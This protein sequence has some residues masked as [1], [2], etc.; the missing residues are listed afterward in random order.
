MSIY[1]NVSVTK[2]PNAR[3]EIKGAILSEEF[4][5]FRLKAIKNIGANLEWP[6]FR[7][8][9]VPEK[10]LVER[11]GENVIL[12]EIAELALREA[13]PDILEEH[14]IEAIGRPRI[15]I[16]K[17]APGNPIEFSAITSIMPKFDLPDY[18]SIAGQIFGAEALPPEITVVEIDEAI[19][20]IRQNMA[21]VERAANVSEQTNNKQ[22]EEGASSSQVHPDE[23]IPEDQLPSIEAVLKKLQAKDLAELKERVKA[24]LLRVEALKRAEQRRGQMLEKLL[25]GFS[26][27]LPEILVE[28]EISRQA[29]M[30]A[31]EVERAGFKLEDYLKQVGRSTEEFRAEFRGPAEKQ[32]RV[33]LVFD[34]IARHQNI[35]PEKSKV[36]EEAGKILARHPDEKLDPESV[37]AYVFTGLLN[38]AVWKFL[39]NVKK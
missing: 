12:E 27:E 38:E 32:V 25:L 31:V 4:Q 19:E 22:D 36:D 34:A 35:V 30:F 24:E 7:K 5:K 18:E 15:N 33:Q 1:S 6:G 9:M 3:V 10:I 13:Y 16:T 26:A 17:L 21:K 11:L 20:K 14:K 8:G 23:K 28:G 29:R 2:L 37:R 39:E